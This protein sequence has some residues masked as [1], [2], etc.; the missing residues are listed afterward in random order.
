MNGKKDSTNIN[1]DSKELTASGKLIIGLIVA[2]IAVTIV[3]V[4]EQ[5]FQAG[6]LIKTIVKVISF[7]GAVGLYCGITKSRFTDVIRLHK[8]KSVYICNMYCR[9]CGCRRFPAVAF[10]QI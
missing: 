9:T 5:V 2:F 6:Y 7:M 10:R 3:F 1:G 4:T 8:L